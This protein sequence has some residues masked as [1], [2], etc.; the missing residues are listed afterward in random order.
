MLKRREEGTAT[1]YH[2]CPSQYGT[3]MRWKPLT[4]L[5]ISQSGSQP[6]CHAFYRIHIQ[7]HIH[8]FMAGPSTKSRKFVHPFTIFFKLG[9]AGY[10]SK[11][12]I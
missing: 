7:I 12:K 1:P 3:Y 9:N 5:L 6:G 11:G 4:Y 8:S 10:A 2:T